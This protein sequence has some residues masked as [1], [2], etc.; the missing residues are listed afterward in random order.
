MHLVLTLEKQYARPR[1]IILEF[2]RP[3][4]TT[5]HTLALNSIKN[6][7]SL[8][9]RINNVLN[10]EI[11]ISRQTCQT[12]MYQLSRLLQPATDI[13]SFLYHNNAI[14]RPIPMDSVLKSKREQKK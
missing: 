11:S 10:L 9:V 3:I 8:F 4:S 5:I 12:D 1:N 7:K 13:L 14:I 6:S 2:E